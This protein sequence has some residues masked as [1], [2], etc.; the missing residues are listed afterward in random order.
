MIV[1]S[2]SVQANYIGWFDVGDNT[3]TVFIQTNILVFCW[4]LV[5]LPTDGSGSDNDNETTGNEE[6]E[7]VQ[8]INKKL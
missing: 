4:N 5:S 6:V 3:V 8:T 1:F 7:K 2:L